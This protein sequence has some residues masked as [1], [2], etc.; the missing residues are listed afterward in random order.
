M[1]SVHGFQHTYCDSF[2]SKEEF[3]A[4]FDT[5]ANAAMRAKYKVRDG[6][7]A[8]ITHRAPPLGSFPHMHYPF[9]TRQAE[10][11]FVGVYDKTRPEVDVFGWL[12]EEKGW[13]A[14]GA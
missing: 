14:E 12:E 9:A 11:A 2:Q 5:A 13:D 4:M 10:G 6:P 3:E 7:R 1:R 8:R